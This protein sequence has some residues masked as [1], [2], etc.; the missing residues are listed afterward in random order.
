MSQLQDMFEDAVIGVYQ[1]GH[2][3]VSSDGC[4]RYRTESGDKCAVGMLISDDAYETRFEGIWVGDI[5]IMEALE[6][7]GYELGEKSLS[8]LECLQH[9][10]DEWKESCTPTEEFGGD[11]RRYWKSTCEDIAEQHKLEMPEL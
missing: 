10:H 5:A 2:A 4:C 1:Q 8:V 9:A 6:K 7:S 11:F 3:S